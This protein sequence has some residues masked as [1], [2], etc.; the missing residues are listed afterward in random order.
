MHTNNIVLPVGASVVFVIVV[1]TLHEYTVA[2]TP[3][4]VFVVVVHINLHEYTH[5][6]IE[7]H[8]LHWR[9]ICLDVFIPW[10]FYTDMH[11][12]NFMHNPVDV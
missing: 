8:L 7:Q 6:L 10:D 2:A 11:G 1:Y 3:S 9:K 5:P 4:V 12:Y